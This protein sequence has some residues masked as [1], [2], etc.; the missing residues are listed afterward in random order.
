MEMEHAVLG[1]LAESTHLTLREEYRAT[2]TRICR[3]TAYGRLRHECRL[4]DDEDRREEQAGECQ[5]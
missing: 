2:H 3:T 5:E 1:L 4:G